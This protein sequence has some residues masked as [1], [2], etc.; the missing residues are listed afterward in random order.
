MNPGRGVI[1]TG[2]IGLVGIV[3]AVMS[4]SLGCGGGIGDATQGPF[5]LVTVDT[6]RA[7][8]IGAYGSTAVPTPHFDRLA[9]EGVLVVD[10]EA[11]AT[12]HMRIVIH[13]PQ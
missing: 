12:G 3:L 10:E 2:S 5:I 13:D 6:T 11:D 7:D 4:L 8:Y 9:E 1:N